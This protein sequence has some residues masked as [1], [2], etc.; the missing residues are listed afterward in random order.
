[1]LD[2]KVSATIPPDFGLNFPQA[3]T[4]LDVQVVKDSNYFCPVDEGTLQ[5][6]ALTASR[7]GSGEVQWDIPYAHAQ[8]WGLPNKSKDINPNA[9]MKWFE[10]ANTLYAKDWCHTYGVQLTGRGPQL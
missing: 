6:S 9:R 7:F 10:E 1:M 3:Q 4:A 5:R 2:I 8:Y